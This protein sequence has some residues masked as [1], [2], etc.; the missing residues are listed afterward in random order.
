[1]SAATARA[2]PSRPVPRPVP[3]PAPRPHAHPA[4]R[5]ARLALVPAARTARPP[6]PRLPF[7]V[8]LVT[9]LSGGLLGL[10]L[11]NTVVGQNAFR[12]H[13][14]AKEGRALAEQEQTL[15][16]DVEAKQAPA[17]LAAKAAALGMVDGGPPAFLRLSDGRVLGQATAPVQPKVAKP[18]AAQPSAKPGVHASAK[19]SPAKPTAAKPS[20][21][22]AAPAK[23]GAAKPSPA[24]TGARR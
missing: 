19:P 12:L 21:A 9:L 4:P 22:K 8:V 6:S 18:A 24:P 17:A 16:R 3:R 1:M 10:L 23:P 13:V 7:V 2:L 20:R 5:R 14:L 11:L 15:R